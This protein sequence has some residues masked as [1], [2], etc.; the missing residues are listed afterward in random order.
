MATPPTIM[1]NKEYSGKSQN[2]LILSPRLW[3]IVKRTI[4]FVVTVV[5]TLV[6]VIP[7]A[8]MFLSSFKSSADVFR[9]SFP[10]TWKT[11][12]PPQPTIINYLKIFSPPNNFQMKMLNSLIVSVSQLVGTLLL[13]A[14]AAY[15]LARLNFIGR[16]FLFGLIMLVS[17]I[18]FEVNMIPL[19]IIIRE[20]GIQNSY[21]A[22]FLPW[23]ANPFGIFLL[24]QAFMEIP[25]DF[26]EAASIEGASR[27]QILWHVIL[28]NTRPTIVTLALMSFLWS[29][30][31]F[32]W[33]L[34][35]ISDPNKQLVQ[36]AVATF[37][38][39]TQLPAWGEIFATS[40]AATVPVL[41]LFIILQKYYIQGAV[42]SGMKG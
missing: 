16:N 11:F 32:F 10:L 42:M 3:R 28:P 38:L 33:P 18:P 2:K 5:V 6:F 14:P 29:W 31:S 25:R 17:F 27:F 7:Y 13:C 8:W 1:K 30:N 9:Y 40:T 22:V 15:V 21:W 12:I 37:T 36:V 4:L 35:V 19:Y 20:L 26:D 23:I 41:M 39:P 24:R 34:I